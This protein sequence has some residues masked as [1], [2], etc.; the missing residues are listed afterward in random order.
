MAP[1]RLAAARVV[2]ILA[3]AAILA[4]LDVPAQDR[5]EAIV[6]RLADTYEITPVPWQGSADLRGFAAG[7]SLAKFPAGDRTFSPG[8][9]IDFLPMDLHDRL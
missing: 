2:W 7:N 5:P 6:A 1:T 3:A 8:E 4:P 9:T